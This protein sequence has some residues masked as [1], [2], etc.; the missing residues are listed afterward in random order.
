MRLITKARVISLVS[1]GLWL[2]GAGPI[3]AQQCDAGQYCPPSIQHPS[4]MNCQPVSGICA[5]QYSGIVTSPCGG[6]PCTFQNEMR[7]CPVDPLV[8]D[9]GQLVCNSGS[10]YYTT[11]SCCVGLGTPTPTPGS[12]YNPS[13][14]WM[15]FLIARDADGNGE[16]RTSPYN[17]RS[18]ISDGSLNCEDYYCLA[19][20]CTDDGWQCPIQRWAEFDAGATVRALGVTRS[21][22][23]QCRSSSTREDCCYNDHGT[24][25]CD[26]GSVYRWAEPRTLWGV[27]DSPVFFSQF[28]AHFQPW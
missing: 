26:D 19:S 11:E 23:N 2:A 7:H 25:V 17:G 10:T 20:M 5:A 15:Y 12:G 24:T 14:A 21:L 13:A 6:T 8:D 9:S 22:P 1:L 18:E 4:Y 28:P 16:I 3:Q 27:E